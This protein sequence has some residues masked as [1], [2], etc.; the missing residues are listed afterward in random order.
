MKENNLMVFKQLIEIINFCK[1]INST[2]E[3]KEFLE[4]LTLSISEKEIEILKEQLKYCLDPMIIFNIKKIPTDFYEDYSCKKLLQVNWYSIK[5]TLDKFTT[6]DIS[7]HEASN[8][9]FWILEKLPNDDKKILIKI[10]KKDLKCGLGIGT[11]NKVFPKLVEKYKISLAEKFNAKKI[12]FPVLIEPKFDGVRLDVCVSNK[13]V[14]LYTRNGNVINSLPTINKSFKNFPDGYYDGE[15]I[16]TTGFQ[17]MMKL[18]FRKEAIDHNFN[19]QFHVWDYLKMDK[20]KIKCN[21]QDEVLVRKALASTIINDMK[22]DKIIF[23]PG[24]IVNSMEELYE[25]FNKYITMGYEGAL[26]K[27]LSEYKFKRGFHWMKLKP[28]QETDV[29][30][31]DVLPGEG[32][33]ENSLGA[34]VVEHNGVKVNVGSGYSDSLRNKIWKRFQ[35]F[36]ETFIGMELEVMFQEETDDG[37]LRF[38]VF[39][40]FKAKINNEVI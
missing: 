8:T 38:P 31:V 16:E 18:I 25:Q 10:I 2:K 33:L 35:E 13:N 26:I 30:I 12:E 9:L 3:K 27:N 36:P 39:K 6:R 19:V 4:E 1:T 34:L 29:K 28:I 23:V 11:V 24:I 14:I 15:I 20:N 7:G 22:S 37:S 17:K 5:K 21:E 32:R 40:R